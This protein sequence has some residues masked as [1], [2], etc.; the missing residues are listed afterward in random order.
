MSSGAAHETEIS[1]LIF[2]EVHKAGQKMR[3]VRAGFLTFFVLI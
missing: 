3:G 2:V 1:F